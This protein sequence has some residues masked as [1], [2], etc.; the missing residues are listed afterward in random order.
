[1]IDLSIDELFGAVRRLPRRKKA[2]KV[3][4][5]VQPNAGVTADYQRRLT[6]LI[7]EMAASVRVEVGQLLLETPP[8]M[9]ELAH[10]DMASNVLRDAIKKM[11]R[12]WFKRFDQ[13]SDRLARY[14]AQSVGR[15]SDGAL[16]KILKDGGMSVEFNMTLAQ[17]DVLNAV[18]AENVA[19]IKS[20]PERYLNQVEGFVMRSVTTGRDQKQL[21]DD[22]RNQ[23]GV[24]KRRAKLI[25][26]DQNEK[27][28][29]AL[30]R[31]R[32]LEVGID[33]GI[34]VHSAAGR[35]PRPTHVKAGRDGVRFDLRKGW[36]DPHEQKW[37]LPGQLINCRCF[38]RPV[39]KE[40]A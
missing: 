7:E 40:Y 20:I 9:A 17:R 5:G 29:A 18:V 33:E 38:W 16:K 25:A 10:D 26:Q 27:A 21:Y 6:G 2:E 34:W 8:K 28:T 22:L 14:F 4:R 37:I 39:M 11:R 32:Q 35:E 31:A 1:V 36:F 23:L 3:G 24:E 30:A 13:M 15:R 12:R 19:L